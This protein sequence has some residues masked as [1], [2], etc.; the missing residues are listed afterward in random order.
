MQSADP[1]SWLDKLVGGCVGVLLGATALYV[2]V[3]LI[4][5]IAAVLLV[6]L[7]VVAFVA[8]VLAWLHSRNRGW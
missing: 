7:G 8:L 6:I 5:S 4:Q 1:R 3:R 2:A